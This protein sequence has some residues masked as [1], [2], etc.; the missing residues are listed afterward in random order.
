MSG[1][2]FALVAVALLAPGCEPSGGVADSVTFVEDDDPRMNAAIEKARA[3]ADSFIAALKA[4]KPGQAG[5]SVKMVFTAGDEGEHMWLA[6]VTYDGTQFHGTINNQP[7]IVKSVALGDEVSVAPAE[8]SD[9]MYIDN[10]KLVG[11]ET[12]R[13][14]RDGLD[15]DERAEFE[16]SLPFT[17]E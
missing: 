9:W 10:G 14:L 3:T 16:K 8:I 1:W 11:G 13:V 12:L 5:F 17:M 6:P 2:R 7:A 4:P 15:A